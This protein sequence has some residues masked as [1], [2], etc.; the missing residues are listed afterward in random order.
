MYNQ[1][2]MASNTG[3][4]NEH[5]NNIIMNDINLVLD[6]Q[7]KDQDIKLQIIKASLLYVNNLGWN[8]KAINA[9][10]ADLDLS[11]ASHGIL[12]KGEYDIV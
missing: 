1:T 2:I 8:T 4:Q 11:T 12:S 10:C 5:T 3:P 9:A 7:A 6:T